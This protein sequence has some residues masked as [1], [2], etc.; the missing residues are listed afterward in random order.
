MGKIRLM[1][2]DVLK[3]H[4]PSIIDLAS[5]LSDLK[6]TDG[7]D[8]NVIEIEKDVENVKITIGG[9]SID[10]NEVKKV[11]EGNSCSIHGVDKVTCGSKIVEEAPTHQD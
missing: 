10:F 11:I 4:S 6:G 1:V 9:D 3:P 2:L 8:I 5:Q 7:V